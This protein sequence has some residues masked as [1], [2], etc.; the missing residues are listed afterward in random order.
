[1]A[2]KDFNRRRAALDRAVAALVRFG[3]VGVVLA[4]SFIAAFLIAESAPLAT[5]PQVEA[6]GRAIQADQPLAVG[7][8]PFVEASWSLRADGHLLFR[9]L[10]SGELIE[11][12][13]LLALEPGERVERVKVAVDQTAL[14]V[15]TSAGRL[16]TAPLR[17]AV[18]YGE[19]LQR[20][21]RLDETA[22]RWL[23]EGG[24]PLLAFDSLS[25]EKTIWGLTAREG[26][27]VEL[28]RGKI[29]VNR[30]TGAE[31]V[32]SKR[33]SLELP[34]RPVDAALLENGSFLI[35]FEDGSL[36]AWQASRDFKQIEARGAAEG[37][38]AILE[39]QPMI[40]AGST[41]VARADGS[42]ERWMLIPQ[43]RGE[44]VLGPGASMPG[45][46]P[47]LKGLVPST[48]QRLFFALGDGEV[49][50]GQATAGEYLGVLET[51]GQVAGLSISPREDHLLLHHADGSLELRETEL[52]F[53]SVTAHTL[54]GKVLYEGAGAPAWTWQ[55]TGGTDAY[56]PKISFV[57]LI[58]GTLKGTFWSLLPSI[59]LA[60]LGALFTARFLR[61]R[62]REIVKPL[63]ELLAGIPSVILGFVGALYLAPA[64]QD[65][66]ISVL[67][68]P[69]A[70][71][72]FTVLLGVVWARL[73]LRRRLVLHEGWAP[74]FLVGAYL[75]IAYGVMQAGPWLEE[76]VFGS[77]FRLW[78]PDGLGLP[79]EQRN[80]AVVGLA[81]GFAVT[82]L[83]FTLAEDAFRNVPETLAEA[84]LALGATK[85]QTAVR[86]IAPPA[87]PGV[88][89]AIMLGLG[90]A[91]GE[92]MIVLMATGNTPI[93]GMNVLQ[94]FR[95]LSANLAVELPEA[96]HGESLY[97]TLF[98][99]ALLLFAFTFLIN[100]LAEV[101]R[102]RGRKA[103]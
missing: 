94:G 91:V 37:G 39:L 51:S 70:L 73:P 26:G 5:G 66:M 20:S 57:P 24:A 60:L 99:S 55:S 41:L 67:L 30:M 16:A 46:V 75:L 11:D 18:D 50:I 53:P 102:V 23:A 33:L 88:V 100:T 21:H 77:S 95:A 78:V 6:S 52:G 63:I 10:R 85:W 28:V 103:L 87:M 38:A 2:A 4:V 27:A 25:E 7:V 40:G 48:R 31:R 98:L 45:V 17:F 83:I 42:V 90:R 97:R 69:I 56:E 43:E 80:A 36:R 47:G 35:A 1:M 9:D 29:K 62:A 8:E 84:S 101:V 58:V 44:P 64:I 19:E 92:T 15:A 3:G 54:F 13:D 96:P 14:A 89:A 34:G 71:V 72:V 68:L 59:P 22:V 82:P 65:R 74:F 32:S 76:A 86:V 61:G 12:R 49:R 79:F 93:T 81:M